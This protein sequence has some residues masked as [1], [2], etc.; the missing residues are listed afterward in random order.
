MT[1]PKVAHPVQQP[2]PKPVFY[3]GNNEQKST[4]I[5]K[6][7]RNIVFGTGC[8][9]DHVQGA[10][11]PSRDLVIERVSK[12]TK[13][14]DLKDY[15]KYKGVC[16]HSLFF[17]SHIDA[18]RQTFKLEISKDDLMKVYDPY[19]WSRGISIRRYFP[20]K[21]RDKRTGSTL[22]NGETGVNSSQNEI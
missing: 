5:E 3:G 17:M 19:F 7:K 8:G 6:R 22:S 14:T 1:I 12:V 18:K 9:S 4:V 15:V 13:E 16:V 11:P 21:G 2:P 20:P 10:P